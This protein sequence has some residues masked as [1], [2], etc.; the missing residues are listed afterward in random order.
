MGPSFLSSKEPFEVARRRRAGGTRTPMAK[1]PADYSQLLNAAIYL[2]F[3]ALVMVVCFVGL[4]PAG[5][6]LQRNQVARMRVVAEIS[7]DYISQIRT[8][9]RAEELRQRM[10]PVYRLDLAPFEAYNLHLTELVADLLRYAAVPE[11][12]PRAWQELTAE[13][14]QAFLQARADGNPYGLRA[15]DL[16]LLYN[17]LGPTG[18]EEAMREGGILLGEVQRQGIYGAAQTIMGERSQRLSLFHVED[19]TGN[20]VQVDILSEEEALRSLR[21]NL[22][23]LDIP[24]DAASVLFRVLRAGIAP[25]LVYDEQR[26][27]ALVNRQLEL[28][29]PVV[30]SVRAGDILIEPDARVTAYQAEQIEAYRRALREARARAFVNTDLLERMV[31]TLFI[32]AGAALYLRTARLRV[33]A[34]NRVFILCGALTVFNLLIIRLVLELGELGI[35][36]VTPGL[37]QLLP[38]LM[39]VALGPIILGILVGSGPAIIAAALLAVFNAMMQG[40]SLVTLVVTL[41]VAMTGIHLCRNIQVR[42]RVVRAGLYAGAVMAIAA[43][44][45]GLRDKVE[46]LTVLLQVLSCL[47]VGL[48]TGIVVVGLLPIWESLFKYTTDITLLE[49]TDY[50]HPL[51][52]R[53]QVE[54]PGS[55][56]HSLMVANLA[57][58][59]AAEIGANSLLCRVCSLYHDIGKLIKPEYFAENQRSGQNPHIERNPSMSALVIKSHVKEGI[60]LARQYKLPRIIREVIQQHHGTTLIQYFYYKAIEQQRAASSI[61]EATIPNAP[62]IELDKVND[63]TYRYEGPIPQFAESALIMLADSIEA[64]SRSLRKPTPHGI[65]QLVDKIVAA[66]LEDGQLDAT[67]ITFHQLAGVRRNFSFTLLNMLHARVEY[68]QAPADNDKRGRTRNGGGNGNPRAQPGAG[69]AGNA[70]AASDGAPA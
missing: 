29:E 14:V 33:Q 8:Q 2:M 47:G 31:L 50:N 57:E 53:M 40:N 68:P 12:A 41:L 48:F 62:R 17:R 55:Y 20:A 15:Q 5:P 65:E 32:V 39:P 67:P 4:N 51:L 52:R 46:P 45:V 23:A 7:Y 34:N 30:V 35:A 16:A 11:G 28:V 37:G 64:A 1:P 9:E 26:S 10:P 60:Q 59:A 22:A 6:P 69:A 44:L 63:A 36:Q 43:A 18:A 70:P 13:E 25:N 19:A 42:A 21:V 27:E 66:R 38:W 56:H 61:E 49:L 54:A 58:N 3:A 24:R